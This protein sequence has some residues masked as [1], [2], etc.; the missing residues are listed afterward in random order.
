MSRK[1]I[2]NYGLIEWPEINFEEIKD[3]VVENRVANIMYKGMITML[4]MPQIL[5]K[6]FHEVLRLKA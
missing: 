4:F 6:A 5:I 2:S 3:Y 1:F